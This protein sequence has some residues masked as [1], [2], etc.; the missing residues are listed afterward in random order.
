MKLIH[1]IRMISQKGIQP[2]LCILIVAALLPVRPVAAQSVTVREGNDFATQVL[3]DPWDM[4]EFSDISQYLNNSGQSINLQNIQVA[5]G[6]FSAQSATNDPQFTALFPGYQTAMLLGKV[7]H[8][9]PIQSSTYKCLFISMLSSS[10]K[11]DNLEVYWFK[12]ERLNGGVWGTTAQ[13]IDKEYGWKQYRIDLDGVGS[14][15]KWNAS[16]T[17]QGLRIDPSIKQANFSVDWI[18][19]TDCNPVTFNVPGIT[20]GKTANVFLNK[21]GHDTLIGQ[22][23][24]DNPALDVQGV[25]A[26]NYTFTAKDAGSSAVLSSGSLTINQAPIAS[27]TRPSPSSGADFASSAGTTWNMADSS[28]VTSIECMT[29]SFSGGVLNLAT[30]NLA[31]ARGGFADPKIYLNT[32]SAAA[33]SQYR[34]F[35]VKI[36]A[37]GPWQNVPDGMILRLVWKIQGSGGAGSECYLVSQDM[38]FDVGWNT[39]NVDLYDGFNGSIEQ[40][41]GECPSSVTSWQNS[42]A[43]IGFRL[44]PNENQL[45]RTLNQK[46]EWVRL[47]AM[48]RVA[49]GAIFPV[50][51]LLNKA[52]T[53][54]TSIKFY[55][56]TNRSNPTQNPASG[57]LDVPTTPP[58]PSARGPYSIFLPSILSTRYT[59]VAQDVTFN[60]NTGGVPAGQYYLCVSLNDGLNGGTYCSDAPVAVE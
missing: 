17:W 19:L 56:T 45:G 39:I 55:Y 18:R 30:A 43:V 9:F 12:D 40:K 23:T 3:R 47:T 13:F 2:A 21:N 10:S 16:A 14:P 15:S 28:G 41:A 7:G 31:C 37:D 11:P 60:W 48:D 53:A 57:S 27:F 32:P 6:I 54:L 50:S 38:P 29:Y 44:D 59:S 33:T 52:P 36:Y 35:S 46:I 49:R 24:S 26:G 42:G 5:N 58:S 51:I 22:V 4:N 8:N 34:Y 1:I 25:E 20:N